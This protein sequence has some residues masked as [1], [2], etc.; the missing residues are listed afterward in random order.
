MSNNIELLTVY[1]IHKSLERKDGIKILVLSENPAQL[2]NL[3]AEFFHYRQRESISFRHACD[4]SFN[5]GTEVHFSPKSFSDRLR[6]IQVDKILI[7]GGE[8]NKS[9][10]EYLLPIVA[11]SPS[12]NEVWLSKLT[13]NKTPDH[14]GVGHEQKLIFA[15][16]DII[17]VD[18]T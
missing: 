17:D 6:G 11:V 2:A 15:D 4:I 1:E 13:H 14:W 7:S 18:F 5:N 9:V 8:I 16:R 12:K 10:Y 3:V